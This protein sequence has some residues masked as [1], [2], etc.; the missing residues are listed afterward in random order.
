MKIVLRWVGKTKNPWLASLIEDYESRIRHFSELT[1]SEVKP[2]QGQNISQSVM[3]EGN[4]LLSKID[5][6]DYLIA[7]DPI[8]Q[9]MGSE[10]F[11]NII[12]E[13]REHSLKKLVFVVGGAGGLS[14]AVKSR[15]QLLVSLSSMTFSHEITRLILVE[16]IYRALTMVNQHPYHK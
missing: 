7:L 11:A 10:K 9:Q 13:R 2:T 16:Q 3:I 12:N 14:S 4:R 8:G 6:D 1:F 15:C 5:R